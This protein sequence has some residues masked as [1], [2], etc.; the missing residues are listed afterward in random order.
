VFSFYWWGFE[1]SVPFLL[2]IIEAE[3]QVQADLT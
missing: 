3:Q 1:S 2:S